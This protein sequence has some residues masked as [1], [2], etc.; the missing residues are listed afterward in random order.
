MY[1]NLLILFAIVTIINSIP[2]IVINQ[3]DPVDYELECVNNSGKW[4]K[5]Y[6]ECEYIKKDWCKE[7]GGVFDE[8]ASACRHNKESQMCIM[9]CVPVCRLK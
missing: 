6:N 7:R 5:E 2:T 8:C 1:N 9:V 4:I 3:D